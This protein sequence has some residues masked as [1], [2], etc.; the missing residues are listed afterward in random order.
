MI[1]TKS[2]P[3][4]DK[5]K[6]LK[7][8]IALESLAMDLKRVALSYH[9]NSII[10]ARRFYEEALKRQKEIDTTSVK[11]YIKNILEKI[12]QLQNYNNDRIAEDSLLFSILLQNYTQKTSL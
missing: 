10:M 3:F 9:R 5:N 2:E 7:N 12:N 1:I 6:T 11:P 4:S 8:K